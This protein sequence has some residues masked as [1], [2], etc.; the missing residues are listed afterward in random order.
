M[1][2]IRAFENRV[3][4][5]YRDSL[6]PGFVH[7]SIGQEAVAAGV[8]GQLRPDDQIT[9]THRGHGHVIAKGGELPRM[10]AELLG[11]RDG[12]CAGKGGSMHIASPALG[13]LGANA[14]VGAGLPLAVGAALS[15]QLTG[16]DRVVVAFFGDGA[17]NQGMS[18]ESFNLAAIWKLPLLFVCENN[19]YAEFTD[20]RRMSRVPEVAQRV[21]A[22]GIPGVRV[23]GNDALQVDKAAVAE[24]AACRK[25][26]G[27]RLLEAVTYRVHG[28]YEGDP[29]AYRPTEEAEMWAARDPL[30][31]AK[32]WLPDETL[33][34]SIL[35]EA[36]SEVEEA[37]KFALASPEPEPATALTDVYA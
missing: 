6:I 30:L 1:A 35:A 37:V 29:Q 7:L 25:G 34:Q 3:A 24:I 32:G 13:V 5:L 33:R 10:L 15:A 22:F 20:S 17:A 9:T 21:A 19:T 14:I 18:L 26:D 11:R 8:C 28:H 4:A 31:V 27:P 2:R 12:Y 16:S 36:E 23:D